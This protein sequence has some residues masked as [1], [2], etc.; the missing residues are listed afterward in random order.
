MPC[1]LEVTGAS[2]HASDRGS[3][4]GSVILARTLVVLDEA[5]K[6]LDLKLVGRMLHQQDATRI[7]RVSE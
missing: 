3:G 6:L 4:G 1:S 7:G 2:Q 5:V